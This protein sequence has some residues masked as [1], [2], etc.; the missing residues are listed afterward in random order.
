MEEGGLDFE[1]S[2][3][4]GHVS[5]AR[6]TGPGSAL[7]RRM[8]EQQHLLAE[9][10]RQAARRAAARARAADADA[11][12]LSEGYSDG[13]AGGDGDDDDDDE[14]P[15]PCQLTWPELWDARALAG[16]FA[17]AHARGARE[18]ER[19]ARLGRD[20]LPPR[21][22]S[23]RQRYKRG[24]GGGGGGG[25]AQRRSA[26]DALVQYS[27]RLSELAREGRPLQLEEEGRAPGGGSGGGRGGAA[28][29]SGSKRRR[30]ESTELPA[31]GQQQQ[32]QLQPQTGQQGSWVCIERW[33]LEGGASGGG[34]AAAAPVATA[35]CGARNHPLDR[36]CAACGAPRW[37]GPGGELSARAAAALQTADPER[38]TP[39]QLAARLRAEAGSCPALGPELPPAMLQEVLARLIA[40]RQR[41]RWQQQQQAG[42]HE[43]QYLEQQAQQQDGQP[44]QAAGGGLSAKRGGGG[45]AKLRIQEALAAWLD[46]RR[47]AEAVAAAAACNNSGGG[48]G[49]GGD[50]P[51]QADEAARRVEAH[52]AAIA[53][54]GALPALWRLA[55][56]ADAERRAAAA[57][58]GPGVAADPRAALP[59]GYAFAGAELDAALAEHRRAAAA[60][61]AAA[62]AVQQQQQQQQQDGRPQPPLASE[63]DSRVRAAPLRRPL[64]AGTLASLLDARAAR[65]RAALRDFARDVAPALP[66][67]M[68][69]AAEVPPGEWALS[70]RVGGGWR[71]SAGG[72]RGGGGADG[73]WRP[74]WEDV[75]TVRQRLA[76]LLADYC[77]T[78]GLAAAWDAAP[79]WRLGDAAELYGAAFDAW[80]ARQERPLRPLL[81]APP[82]G[83]RRGG[84]GGR[85]AAAGGGK[86]AAAAAVARPLRESA[87]RRSARLHGQQVD[88]AGD[89]R[90]AAPQKDAAA[91]A[92]GSSGSSSGSSDSSD[93]SSSSESELDDSDSSSSSSSSEDD[94]SSTE[95]EGQAGKKAAR[96]R[97]HTR[98]P[99]VPPGRRNRRPQGALRL[100]AIPVLGGS[101]PHEL[102]PAWW[103]ALPARLPP[104]PGARFAPRGAPFRP[105]RPA[106]AAGG[107]ANGDD[108]RPFGA[109]LAS[110]ARAAGPAP[111]APWETGSAALPRCVAGVLA[112]AR[113]AGVAE[114]ALRRAAERL[115]R[116]LAGA[117]A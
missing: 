99:S 98:S 69:G 34:G 10:A 73:E 77:P 41:Q 14:V 25:G 66:T 68:A 86:A 3:Q 58:E 26:V 102:G 88:A 64:P 117:P 24:G 100:P 21:L 56:G 5:R 83:R 59:L 33:P 85:A 54:A 36:A 113:N 55:A 81:P 9:Q 103:A 7:A 42:Q 104:S 94:G 22:L 115:E 20:W 17:D 84:A 35:P 16:G 63:P 89:A 111:P 61:A 62:A 6:L 112:A 97:S 18:S 45:G 114:G 52:A 72:R 101:G 53:A 106:A 47:A 65:V 51:R 93:S 91:G 38:T 15:E 11:G 82:T 49:G 78:Q 30:A 1:P 60:A 29:R 48:S 57:V 2:R 31:V 109:P 4:Y 75:D 96:E 87:P 19:R 80:L 23:H 110:S 50:E 44:A 90:A 71:V 67:V 8:E 13:D 46:E 108:R 12:A 28:A 74:S 95:G 116:L 76:A 39:A 43:R 79:P 105:W 70:E 37:D 92:R 27:R 107:G 32:Q 40:E